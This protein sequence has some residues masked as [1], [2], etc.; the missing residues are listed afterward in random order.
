MLRNNWYT[1]NYAQ[2][3]RTAMETGTLVAATGSGRVAS[4]PRADY[5]EGAAVVLT[6]EGHEDKVYEFSGDHAWDFKEL[7]ATI[8]EAAGCTCSYKPVTRDELKANLMTVGLDEGTAGFVATLDANIAEGS[9]ADARPDLAKLIG[10][11]TTPLKE[12]V[13]K[14]VR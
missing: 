4:A 2:S 10:R 9:L 1:E 6:G 5:A 8:A 7:A 13:K 3:I 12:T 14:I 11:P